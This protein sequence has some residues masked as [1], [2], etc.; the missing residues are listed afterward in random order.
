MVGKLDLPFSIVFLSIGASN[1]I[2]YG[3]SRLVLNGWKICLGLV[4]IPSIIITISGIILFNI[5][6]SLIH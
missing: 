2:N 5:P 6:I 1:V 3:T 4:I